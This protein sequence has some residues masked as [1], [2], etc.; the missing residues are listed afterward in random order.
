MTEQNLSI[1]R[2]ERARKQLAAAIDF[3]KWA[4]EEL[5]MST[6]SGL[7]LKLRQQAEIDVSEAMT[8]LFNVCR[9]EDTES[10]LLCRMA[11]ERVRTAAKEFKMA[12]CDHNEVVEYLKGIRELREVDP[13]RFEKRRDND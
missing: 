8:T 2:I 12:E 1:T 3:R 7:G 9:E 10:E 6:R 11:D 5:F 13:I 4:R